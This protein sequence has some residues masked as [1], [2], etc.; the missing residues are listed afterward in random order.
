MIITRKSLLTGKIREMNIEVTPDEL[1]RWRQG[2][3]I[4]VA[5]PQLSTTEREFIMTGIT[6][7]EWNET[8]SE[9]KG[10]A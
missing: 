1:K 8:F 10:N 3:M 4:Q 7:D 9:E 2:E 5:M 6:D